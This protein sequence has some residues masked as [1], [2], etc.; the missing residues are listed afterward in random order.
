MVKTRI[1]LDLIDYYGVTV[2][3][4]RYQFFLLCAYV[5]HKVSERAINVLKCH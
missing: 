5:S 4:C 3:V 2:F 1:T